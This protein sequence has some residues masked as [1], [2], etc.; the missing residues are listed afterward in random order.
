MSVSCVWATVCVALG[1][2]PSRTSTLQ[3]SLSSE[4]LPERFDGGGALR[5]VGVGYLR[6][7]Q[8]PTILYKAAIKCPCT[9]IFARFSACLLGET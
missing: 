3:H 7:F 9:V 5:C 6:D 8:A 1:R 2:G 4:T